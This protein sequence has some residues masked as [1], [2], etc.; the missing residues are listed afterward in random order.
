M[1]LRRIVKKPILFGVDLTADLLVLLM[2]A[3]YRLSPDEPG[4]APAQ[5]D[6]FD[7]LRVQE[8]E[9][10]E[11]ILDRETRRIKPEYIEYR[12]CP[13][14]DSESHRL[15][16]PTQDFFDYVKC[17]ECGF[18]Y[19]WQML[20][21]E[22]RTKIYGGLTGT[23]AAEVCCSPSGRAA[24]RERFNFPL[25]LILKYHRGGNLL[26]VG[27][28]VGNFLNQAR[29]AG[30][31]VQGIETH[32][33]FREAAKASYHIDVQTG[34]FEEM[35]LPEDHFQV[36]TMW[37]TLEH[38]YHPKA[39]IKRAFEILMPKGIL[40]ISVPNLSNLGFFML[41]EYSAHRGGEHINFFSP[42]TLSRMLTDCGFTVVESHT[43]GN[44]DWGA[45]VN[46]L[47]LDLDKVYCYDNVG[48]KKEA[49]PPTPFFAPHEAT[50]LK[51]VVFPA[52]S[53]YESRTGKGEG[54]TILARKDV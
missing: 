3:M 5:A 43:T 4:G 47:N 22:A 37:E 19:A 27:C 6:N 46:L 7:S 48:R 42:A 11:A 15:V 23:G 8:K 28:G 45:M 49:T 20:T 39:A 41:R 14:C 50:F 33:E 29:E 40:A 25:S 18:V 30:F 34:I 17:Q 24:D 21:H 16:F 44:S 36:V 32:P 31:S 51:R 53:R 52:L 35:E 54:I 2:K 9:Q 38:I 12:R 10:F 13:N 1:S 26:D